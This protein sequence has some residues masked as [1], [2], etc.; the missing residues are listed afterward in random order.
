MRKG[1]GIQR[2]AV[3]LAGGDMDRS[4]QLVE[5][6]TSGARGDQRLVA[7]SGTMARARAEGALTGTV[8][9]A[10]AAAV[11]AEGVLT[12]TTAA[13]VAAGTEVGEYWRP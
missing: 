4:R 11:R 9:A 10:A 3:V 5:P 7:A 13:A 8:A 6:Q 2:P 1:Q 12:G